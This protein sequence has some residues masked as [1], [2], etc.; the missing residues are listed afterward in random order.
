MVLLFQVGDSRKIFK[1]E[2]FRPV[3][4]QGLFWTLVYILL[5]QGMERFC[6]TAVNFSVRLRK[7]Q[8][9]SWV[10]NLSI[11]SGSR[12]GSTLVHVPTLF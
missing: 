2:F 3:K 7:M 1:E 5:R 8:G 9:F 4:M 11:V 6:G 12:R 10:V